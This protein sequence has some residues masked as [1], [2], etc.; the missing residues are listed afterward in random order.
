MPDQYGLNPNTP[1]P[2][3]PSTAIGY[4]LPEA[5]KVRLAIYNLLGQEVRLLVN[6]RK[7]AGAF[8]VSWDGTDALGR[9]VASAVYL[10]RTQAADFSASKRMLLLK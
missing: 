3:N 2:F 9:R 8:K 5:G 10:Y 4:Q 1:N 7:D 6:E